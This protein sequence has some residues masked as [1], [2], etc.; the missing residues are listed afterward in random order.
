MNIKQLKAI[1]NESHQ[2]FKSESEWEAKLPDGHTKTKSTTPSGTFT[3][4]KHKGSLIGQFNHTKGVG[5]IFNNTPIKRK[6]TK[7]QGQPWEHYGN[8]NKYQGD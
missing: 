5:T 8:S 4:V 6:S 1:L 3:D 7:D 2:Q